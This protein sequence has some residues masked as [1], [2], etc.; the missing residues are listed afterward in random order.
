MPEMEVR[1][2]QL[3]TQLI[4][5]AELCIRLVRNWA[6]ILGVRLARAFTGKRKL[7]RFTEHYHGWTDLM[8]SRLT[9][10]P[11]GVVSGIG[12]D[13]LVARDDEIDSVVQ[14]LDKH[15]GVA[16]VVVEPIGANTGLR[17]CREF[18][19]ALR[20]LTQE[21]GVVLIFDEIVTAFRIAPGG[22]QAHYNVMPDLTALAKVVCGGLQ[23][24]AITGRKD[25]MSLLSGAATKASGKGVVPHRARLMP[26]PSRLSPALPL[27]KSSPTRMPAQRPM[28]TAVPF[29]AH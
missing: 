10:T 9:D 21:R 20:K 25:I 7:I 15:N 22:A 11:R 8:M 26:I 2:A 18:L 6:T 16:G 29:A 12:D 13:V 17:P 19:T 14:L 28:N 27:W 1:W 5:S 3:V 4:P 23:G 24:G